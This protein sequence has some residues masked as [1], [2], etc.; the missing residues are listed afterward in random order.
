M[1]LENSGSENAVVAANSINFKNGIDKFYG[2]EDKVLCNHN[3]YI[4]L[5]Y[6]E[7]Y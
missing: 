4:S 6:H 2:G 7:Q 5:A 3:D 1:K